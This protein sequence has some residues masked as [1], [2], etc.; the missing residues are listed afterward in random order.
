VAGKLGSGCRA[1]ARA[2]D[3]DRRPVEQAQATFGRRAAA[4][5]A[6]SAVSGVG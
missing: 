4:A 2:D 6:S 5:G 1:L 3:N